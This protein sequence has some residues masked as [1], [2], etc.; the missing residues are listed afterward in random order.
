MYEAME[1]V[2]SVMQIDGWF[3]EHNESCVQRECVG[4]CNSTIMMQLLI[5]DAT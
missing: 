3:F 5:F 2:V 1:K 4:I